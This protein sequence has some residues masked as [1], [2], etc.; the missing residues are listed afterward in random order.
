MFLHKATLPTGR[1]SSQVSIFFPDLSS[2][3]L[4]QPPQRRQCSHCH[5]SDSLSHLKGVSVRA[6]IAVTRSATSRASAFAL[7]SQWL[8]QSPQERQRSHCHRS[9]SLSHLKSVSVR[10]VI[11]VTRSATWRASAFALSSQW[12]AQPPQ[13]HQCSHCYCSVLKRKGMLFISTCYVCDD[14]VK[15][16]SSFFW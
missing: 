6:V 14:T 9:D 3:W 1:I 12:L 5:R 15:T 7:S 11:A 10:T 8:A 2:Q 4:A 13:E 16:F